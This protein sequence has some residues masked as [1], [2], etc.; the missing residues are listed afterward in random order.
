[1][2]SNFKVRKA[3]KTDLDTIIQFNINMAWETEEKE[4]PRG[5]IEPGVYGLFEKPEY[6]FYIVA[7]KDG[8]IAGSLMITYEWSDWRNGLFWWIQSVYVPKQFR[9]QG[10]YRQ[11]YEWVK[12]QSAG[13]KGV[14]GYRLYVEKENI[15]AQ[16]TYESLGMEQCIYYM[17]EEGKN[18]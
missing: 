1:M 3:T 15:T 7:E 16:K 6:G 2:E 5:K 13:D 8:Q 14:C 9:R 18:A 17:Y 4:L 11:M 10:V 12:E